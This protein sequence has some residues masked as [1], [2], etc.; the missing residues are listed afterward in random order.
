MFVTYLSRGLQPQRIF[1][2]I[3]GLL[4]FRKKSSMFEGGAHLKIKRETI[5]YEFDYKQGT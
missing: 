5:L 3:N 4:P 1:D 2:R